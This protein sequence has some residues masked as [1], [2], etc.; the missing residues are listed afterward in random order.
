MEL[1]GAMSP[2]DKYSVQP[3]QLFFV[4]IISFSSGLA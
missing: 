3:E 2:G 1:L 4:V